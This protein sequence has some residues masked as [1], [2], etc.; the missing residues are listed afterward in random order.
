MQGAVSIEAHFQI[1]ENKYSIVLSSQHNLS[2]AQTVNSQ[3][4]GL[5]E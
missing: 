4:A 5:F 2:H 3:H 1:K